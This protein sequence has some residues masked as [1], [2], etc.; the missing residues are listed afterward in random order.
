MFAVS[1]RARGCGGDRGSRTREFAYAG[2]RE[3]RINPAGAARSPNRHRAPASRTQ[4][5]PTNGLNFPEPPLFNARINNPQPW[6]LTGPVAEV[7]ATILP[8]FSHQVPPAA[9]PNFQ[10]NLDDVMGAIVNWFRTGDFSATAPK[11]FSKSGGRAFQDPDFGAVAEAMR[12]LEQAGL[13][14]RA[15]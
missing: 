3:R 12:V 10:G 4:R 8:L 1:R 7:A 6:W 13:L 9:H 14:M 15:L 5:H 2:K 11:A